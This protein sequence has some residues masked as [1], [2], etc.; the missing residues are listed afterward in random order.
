[1]TSAFRVIELKLG[2]NWAALFVQSCFNAA[3]FCLW[4]CLS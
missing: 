3:G 4:S 1:M 2:V